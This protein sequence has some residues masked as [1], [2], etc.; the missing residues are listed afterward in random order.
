MNNSLQIILLF[1]GTFAVLALVW[2]IPF[3][4][5]RMRTEA[6]KKKMAEQLC[7]TNKK[8]I[9]EPKFALYRG[10]DAQFGFVKGNGVICLTENTLF[11]EKLT[12]RRIQINRTEIVEATV[13]FSFKGKTSLA[14]GGRHLVIRTKDGNR[15]GF[16]VKDAEEWSQKV[17]SW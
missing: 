13:E 6:L 2:I 16:L 10:A 1:G 7:R 17:N 14:T 9:I 15:I 4:W 11:F 3:L 5:I 12:G 8:V